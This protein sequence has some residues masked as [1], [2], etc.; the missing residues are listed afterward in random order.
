MGLLDET[1][2]MYGEDLDWAFRIKQRGWQVWYNP[3]VTVLH[4]KEAASKTSS[5]A[6]QE[7]YRA[8]LIFYRKHY[9]ATTPLLLHWAIVGGIGLRGALDMAGRTVV[10][11]LSSCCAAGKSRVIRNEAL[12]TAPGA[13]AVHPRYRHCAWPSSWPIASIWRDP[14]RRRIRA[15]TCP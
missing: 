6:R 12:P 8:M 7:F 10:A 15:S 13:G 11:R 4:V 1:F 3:A 14:E 5:K 2:F 9:Q